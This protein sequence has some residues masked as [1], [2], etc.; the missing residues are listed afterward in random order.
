MSGPSE[1]SGYNTEVYII[2]C[3]CKIHDYYE[4]VHMTWGKL[5]EL[6]RKGVYFCPICEKLAG[7]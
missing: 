2:Q 6:R 3:H 7:E 4:I 1:K 5:I